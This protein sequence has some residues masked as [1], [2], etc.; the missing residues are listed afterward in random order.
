MK[1]LMY[2]ILGI[3]QGFTEPIPVS[4]SGHLVIF[5]SILNVKE[6]NDLNFEIFVNFGSFIAITFFYRKEIL[7][8][9][10]DFFLYIKTK[11]EKYKSNYKYAWMIVIGTIPAGIIGLLFKNSIENFTS[12]KIVG[13]SLLITAFMLFMIKDF[14]GNKEKKDMTLKDSIIIGLFQVIAL[15][16]G[17]SRSGSTLVGG[18]SRNLTRETAFKYSFMLYIPI[19]IATMILGVKDVI[20]TGITSTLL[21]PYL[22]GMIIA[23]IV[24]YFSIKWFKK[25]MEKGKLIYFVYYCLFAGIITILFIK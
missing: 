1:L 10:N 6:L 21:F 22:L 16:P 25:I 2:I 17:I 23:G 19:S 12:V 13:I 11:K 14:K 24:T 7:E 8:I 20:S 15:F 3:I 9:I 4:S 5:N 18:M